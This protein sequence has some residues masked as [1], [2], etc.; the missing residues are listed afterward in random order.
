MFAPEKIKVANTFGIRMNYFLFV[1]EFQGGSNG[2]C[3]QS[4]NPN[5]FLSSFRFCVA[6]ERSSRPGGPAQGRL[7]ILIHP[8]IAD[9]VFYNVGIFKKEERRLIAF[10]ASIQVFSF[11]FHDL[12]FCA[13][14]RR[15]SGR[16]RPI[17]SPKK[18]DYSKYS[19]V[20]SEPP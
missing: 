2:F 1:Q 19:L 15:R 6:G 5:I 10:E 8:S 3:F 11:H 18:L 13:I 4:F 12:V 14:F 17:G 20:D 9:E 16:L 7:Q